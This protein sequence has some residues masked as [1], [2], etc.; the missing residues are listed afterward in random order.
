MAA[1]DIKLLVH[2]HLLTMRGEVVGYV[3]DG[4]V[5]IEGSCSATVGRCRRS[6]R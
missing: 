4:A 1:H 2:A 5:A 3:P 6:V